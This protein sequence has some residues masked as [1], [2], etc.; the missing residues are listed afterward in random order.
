VSQRRRGIKVTV[1]RFIILVGNEEHE[2]KEE[3]ET[4]K[5]ELRYSPET[6]TRQ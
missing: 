3:E 1:N 5:V 2:E 4:P 6:R